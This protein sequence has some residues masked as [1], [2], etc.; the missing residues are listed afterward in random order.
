MP[1]PKTNSKAKGEMSIPKGQ[2]PMAKGQQPRCQGQRST[3]NE[4]N[5]MPKR[6]KANG[7]EPMAN[8]LSPKVNLQRG[9]T[10]IENPNGQM[11]ETAGG[12]KCEM[13]KGLTIGL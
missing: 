13:P 9:E 7:Q 8:A 5:G 2:K 1:K 4:G 11:R 10:G 12:K 6:Q 3:V